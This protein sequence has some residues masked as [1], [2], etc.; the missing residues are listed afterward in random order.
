L[1]NMGFHLLAGCT[2][3]VAGMLFFAFGWVGGGDAKLFATAALWLGWDALFEYALLA[4]LLGGCLTL[5]L[6]LLRQMPLPPILTVQPWIARL[7]DRRGGVPYGV[8]IALA[9]LTIWPGTELFR[10]AATG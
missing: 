5:M 10:I 1:S 2:A 9:A 3:L 7:A 8:A 6:L 4:A